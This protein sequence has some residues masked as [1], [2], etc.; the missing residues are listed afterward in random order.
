MW[1]IRKCII[2]LVVCLLCLL[3]ASCFAEEVQTAEAQL[4]ISST[5]LTELQTIT[6]E[7]DRLLI[8]LQQ[9]LAESQTNSDQLASSLETY[10]A[11]L[12]NRQQQLITLQQR[13]VTANQ[14]LA[15]A[16]NL[17]AT[18]NQS[19]TMLSKEVKKQQEIQRRELYQHTF[20]GIVLR[21]YRR[22]V[23]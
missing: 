13:L 5:E 7:Q 10:Q 8:Q 20:W 11:A 15:V 22:I 9:Q 6:D 3:P 1:K 18:Q 14:S 2:L 17:I 16:S 23:R 21:R 4:T 12:D 19:L